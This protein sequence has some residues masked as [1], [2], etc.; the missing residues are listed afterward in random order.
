VPRVGTLFLAN[1]LFADFDKVVAHPAF[2]AGI[3]ADFHPTV[4]LTDDARG[5]PFIKEGGRF[6]MLTRPLAESSGTDTDSRGCRF[7]FRRPL[8]RRR[9][10]RRLRMGGFGEQRRR[11]DKCREEQTGDETYCQSAEGGETYSR[12][13]TQKRQGFP[14]FQ[15]MQPLE[16]CRGTGS[17]LFVPRCRRPYSDGLHLDARKGV[18]V[19][20]LVV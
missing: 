2:L 3:Q 5:M 18:L 8:C 13:C 9:S 15:G 11:T 12:L 17:C 20:W 14:S 6:M 4:A 10:L 19:H 16:S 7:L 1:D